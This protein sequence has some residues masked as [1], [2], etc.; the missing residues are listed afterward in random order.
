MPF[1]ESLRMYRNLLKAA[2]QFVDYNIRH[3]ALRTIKLRFRESRGITDAQE[4]AKLQQECTE[5]LKLIQRQVII[6]RMY[7]ENKVFLDA[8]TSKA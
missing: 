6:G 1:T 5:S 4:I 7:A 8:K 2:S 3:Y